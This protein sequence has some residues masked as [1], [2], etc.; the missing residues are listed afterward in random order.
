M[1]NGLIAL[2]AALAI[3]LAT[4][5]PG[6]GQGLTGAKAVEAMARQPEQAGP[7]RTTMILAFALMESLAIYGLLIAIILVVKVGYSLQ[8]NKKDD[9]VCV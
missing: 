9:K 4:I 6:I 8:P 7:I 3:A 2:A 5:G 1:E